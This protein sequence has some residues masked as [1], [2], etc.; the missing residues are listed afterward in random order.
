MAYTVSSLDELGDGPG[1]R[2]VRGAL[3]V[4]AFGV[5]GLVL[6]AGYEGPNHYHDTQDE[7]YFV[8][9]GTAT[10]RFDDGE[11]EVGPGGIVHVESTTH[12]AISNRT[13]EELVI[14]IVGGK[15]GYVDRDGHLVDPEIDL[16]RRQGI[17]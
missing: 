9:K 8:H 6:A 2:K 3:N 16:P 15:D 12:R 7:L 13:D 11:R 1:F 4:T 14:F 10:F 17:G 5:N